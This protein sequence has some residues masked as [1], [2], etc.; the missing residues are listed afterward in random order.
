MYMYLDM[1]IKALSQE[2]KCKYTK[3]PYVKIII[4]K[5]FSVVYADN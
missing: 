2:F 4:E 1:F 5:C 3:S